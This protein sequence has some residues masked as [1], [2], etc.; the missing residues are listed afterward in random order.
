MRQDRCACG[1]RHGMGRGDQLGGIG[2]D[3]PQKG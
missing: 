3:R 2:K 1:I